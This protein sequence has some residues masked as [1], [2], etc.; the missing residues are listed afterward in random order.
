MFM[1]C[2]IDNILGLVVSNSLQTL[3]Y[4]CWGPQLVFLSH[5][6]EIYLRGICGLQNRFTLDVGQDKKAIVLVLNPSIYSSVTC[7]FS[8][9][10]STR[11]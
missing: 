3:G 2:Q 9:A 4:I 10:N 5:G 11:S 8:K 6:Q 7:I 1:T